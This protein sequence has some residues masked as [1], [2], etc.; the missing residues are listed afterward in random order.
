MNDEP[1]LP[2]ESEL[3][4]GP[5]LVDQDDGEFVS[6]DEFFASAGGGGAD[7]DGSELVRSGFVTLVGRPNVGKSTLMNFILG[8][9]VSITSDKPQTTRHQ[10][11]Y[12]AG[13]ALVD[14]IEQREPRGT[15]EEF[16]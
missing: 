6:V 11:R 13:A 1:D 15:R 10:I 9:K 7:A 12:V 3:V 8:T 2:D 4:D 16:A 5:D 14:D